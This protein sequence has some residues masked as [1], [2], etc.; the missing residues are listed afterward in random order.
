MYKKTEEHISAQTNLHG[1]MY[2]EI[3]DLT[4]LYL[5]LFIS[6]SSLVAFHQLFFLNLPV[7]QWRPDWTYLQLF[8]MFP[9]LSSVLPGTVL[10]AIHTPLG[11]LIAFSYLGASTR[12][13]REN[14]L[15]KQICAP[16][17]QCCYTVLSLTPCKYCCRGLRFK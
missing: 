14:A 2:L 17:L 8:M 15:G 12:S 10:C 9:V 4:F 5:F 11:W 13:F 1:Q 3:H 16:V 7:L 6:F